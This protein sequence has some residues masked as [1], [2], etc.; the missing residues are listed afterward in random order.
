MYDLKRGI[1]DSIIHSLLVLCSLRSLC[2]VCMLFMHNLSLLQGVFHISASLLLINSTEDEI[3]FLQGPAFGLFEE[4]DDE[5]THG[6]AEDAKHK[7]SFPANLIDS[8][9]GN[10]RNDE[11]E[12]PLCGGTE[13]D[14]VGAKTSWEDLSEQTM[15]VGCNG[16]I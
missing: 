15:L 3:H 13:A 1:Y 11:V 2:R 4:Y 12:Q 10:F 14:T 5:G 7:E 9:R 6:K 16:K 8:T